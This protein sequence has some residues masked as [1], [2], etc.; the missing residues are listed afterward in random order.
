MG[1]PANTRSVH[2]IW[3]RSAT[4]VWA[5][6][7]SGALLYLDGAN[8]WTKVWQEPSNHGIASIDGTADRLFVASDSR[9]HVF[10][11]DHTAMPT[12]YLIPQ[13]RQVRQMTVRGNEEAYVVASLNNGRGFYHYDGSQLRTIAEPTDIAELEAVAALPGQP[14][15]VGGN[16]RIYRYEQSTL[17]P[18]TI[19]WPMGWDMND[20][21]LFRFEGFGQVDGRVYAVGD[22]HM[23]FERGGDRTWRVVYAPANADDELLAIAGSGAVG[24]AVGGTSG[25]PIVRIEGK[26]IAPDPFA[27][28]FDLAAVWAADANTWFASGWVAN[29]FDG[30]I[31]RGTR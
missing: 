21:L 22:R 4:E 25:G 2:A 10:V 29:S 5:G 20:I 26:T 27:Q 8:G 19:E 17:T 11:G 6:T 16:G 15:F 24:F 28:N 13:V 31:L 14:V 23:V 1:L 3:G 7:G 30:V 12:G 18:E 9:L